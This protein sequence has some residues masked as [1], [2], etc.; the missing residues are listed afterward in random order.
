MN[1]T[2][3]GYSPGL[4]RDDRPRPRRPNR[5]TKEPQVDAA[6]IRFGTGP[7]PDFPDTGESMSAAQIRQGAS[8]AECS[9]PSC[10]LGHSGA[11]FE[12]SESS[13]W[14]IVEQRLHTRQLSV[15]RIFHG[16]NSPAAR[17]N[18]YTLAAGGGM[19]TGRRDTWQDVRRN[20]AQSHRFRAQ[21]DDQEVQTHQSVL[22]MKADWVRPRYTLAPL[23]RRN[24]RSARSIQLPGALIVRGSMSV[25]GEWVRSWI[26]GPARCSLQ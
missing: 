26:D 23:P 2:P 1:P 4:P 21:I 14:A 7:R 6:R 20:V 8:R 10:R 24:I 12:W 3:S 16:L 18:S 19:I 13:R 9:I 11:H 15:R 17:P 5:P 25:S 22:K